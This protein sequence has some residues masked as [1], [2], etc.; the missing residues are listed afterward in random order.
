[1][2]R[3]YLDEDVSIAVGDQLRALG[4]DVETTDQAGR[5]GAD[6]SS[7]LA[8]ANAHNRIVVTHNRMHFRRLHRA[9]P[10][11]KGIVECTRDDADP[12][13]LADRIHD[14]VT[15]TANMDGRLLRVYRPSNP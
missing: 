15:V 3:F 1:M 2:A 10:N 8:Y 4:H 5:K 12:S 6:D 14:A 9:D 7:Q 11:H 13:G